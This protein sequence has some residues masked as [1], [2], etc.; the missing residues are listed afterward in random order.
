[1]VVRQRMHLWIHEKFAN[2]TTT[3][4]GDDDEVNGRVLIID[5]AKC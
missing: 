4:A 3:T 5:G 1:M 2:S